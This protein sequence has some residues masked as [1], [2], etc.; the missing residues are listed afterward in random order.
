MKTPDEIKEIESEL[1]QILYG[2]MDPE[3]ELNIVDLGLI[4]SLSYD[5]QSQVEVKMTFSTPACP[6]GDAILMNIRQSIANVYPEFEVDIEVVFEPIWNS[7]MISEKGRLL[8][9]M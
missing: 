5:G 9:G 8:L 2:V 4:Y 7:E 6:L 3:I 1:E